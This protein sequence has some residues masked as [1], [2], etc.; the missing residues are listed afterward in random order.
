[1]ARN[2]P[3]PTPT[4]GAYDVPFVAVN[5]VRSVG[6]QRAILVAVLEVGD[7]YL[8]I[9]YQLGIAQVVLCAVKKG[10]FAYFF[11]HTQDDLSVVVADLKS[12]A[13]THGATLE[14]I[15][16]L[17]ELT[18]LT[19]EEETIMANPKLSKKAEPKAAA[20]EPK[21]GKGEALAAARAARSSAND[22]KKIKVVNKA[23]GA[24]EGSKRAA[25]L[26]IVLGAKTVAEAKEAGA[27][28]IDVKFA[29]ESGFISL[30]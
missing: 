24:R 11:N 2:K 1:M 27:G 9:E 29:E 28:W 23:H 13:L 10:S 3:L 15:Q 16:L 21:A 7:G 12:K 17:R 8:C 14:A 4:I 19:Y 30:S 5:V 18:E 22:A 25:M 6:E 20:K 26:D